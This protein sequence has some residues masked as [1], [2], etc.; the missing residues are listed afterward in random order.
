MKGFAGDSDIDS[1]LLQMSETESRP[2]IFWIV[3]SDEL[4][5]LPEM[6]GGQSNLSSVWLDAS[7]PY[8]CVCFAN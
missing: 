3:R 1:A 2:T 7:H 6:S 8:L 5:A 4:D